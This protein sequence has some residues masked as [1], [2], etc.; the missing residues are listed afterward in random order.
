MIDLPESFEFFVL[1]GK[2]TLRLVAELAEL[3]RQTLRALF[4][5]LAAL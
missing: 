4:F 5:N 3:S 1:L 2:A